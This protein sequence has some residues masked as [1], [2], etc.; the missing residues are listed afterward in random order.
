MCYLQLIKK[1]NKMMLL[2]LQTKLET[3]FFI[4]ELFLTDITWPEDEEALSDEA[5]SA[6]EALLTVDAD[7]RPAAKGIETE[8]GCLVYSSFPKHCLICD[9]RIPLSQS[10]LTV[11]MAQWNEP[12]TF[13]FCLHLEM[14]LSLLL[15][16]FGQSILQKSGF[17]SGHFHCVFSSFESA[18]LIIIRNG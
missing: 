6:I 12:T 5:R 17:F 4:R 18:A 15:F 11:A 16:T 1:T 13:S 14:S 7:R 2:V 8:H 10:H 3:I 9:Q